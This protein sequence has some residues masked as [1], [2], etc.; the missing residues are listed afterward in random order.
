MNRNVK[1]L[2]TIAA[3]VALL[4]IFTY[5]TMSPNVVSCEVCIEFRGNTECRKASAKT[6][7]DAEMAAASTACGLISGGVGDSIACQ[8]TVPQRVTCTGP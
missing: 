6:R 8:N 7:E 2:V 4:G 5:L 1:I 3:I